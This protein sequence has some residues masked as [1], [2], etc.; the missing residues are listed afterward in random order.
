M[1]SNVDPEAVRAKGYLRRYVWLMWR[2]RSCQNVEM[3][4]RSAMGRGVV[5]NVEMQARYKMGRE[6]VQNF[7][8]QAR[9]KMGRGVVQN[10]EMQACWAMGRGEP[11]E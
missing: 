9:Y 4:A 7:E 8:V 6:V 11:V 1:R 5:Q 3:Q 2:P 10:V